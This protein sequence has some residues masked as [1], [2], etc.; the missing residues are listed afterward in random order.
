MSALKFLGGCIVFVAAM[1]AIGGWMVV[2]DA[3]MRP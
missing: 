3:V 2:L 1:A